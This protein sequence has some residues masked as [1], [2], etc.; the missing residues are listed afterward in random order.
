MINDTVDTLPGEYIVERII[1]KKKAGK[2]VLYKVKWDGYSLEESTWEPIEN[3]SGV[4]NLIEEFEKED[5]KRKLK[6]IKS[7]QIINK[8]TYNKIVK[9]ERVD[10]VGSKN[11]TINSYFSAVNLDKTISNPT[12]SYNTMILD[13]D[14]NDPSELNIDVPNKILR[15]T[16]I[17]VSEKLFN[18]LVEF[19]PRENGFIPDPA[20]YCSDVI[21]EKYPIIFLDYL[22]QYIEFD[23]NL[24][25]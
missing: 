11:K 14:R 18:C 22:L 5:T 20:W 23:P 13:E 25:N 1:D 19:K 2:K 9:E 4:Q 15:L 21:R 12:S 24:L 6:K 7:S 16:V 3:L 8:T 17:S 10:S